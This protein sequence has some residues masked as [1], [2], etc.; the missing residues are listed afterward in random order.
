MAENFQL[1]FQCFQFVKTKDGNSRNVLVASA[2]PK[3]YSYAAESGQRLAVWPEDTPPAKAGSNLETEGP[4]EKRRKVDP[5][6]GE[7]TGGAPKKQ[8]ACWSNIPI[9]TS[10]PDGEYVVA[11]TAEDKCI[12][13]F[14]ITGNG[15]FQQLSARVMPKRAC[16]ITFTNK[17][18]ILCGDKFGD[19]Y[20]LP[21]I[22]S[23]EPRISKASSQ[24]RQ[25]A[26]ATPLTV[27]T[28]RN[29]KSLEMQ[30]RQ[31]SN[32]QV[33]DE[34]TF[35]HELLL[36]HVS[37]L[38]DVAFVSLP[39]RDPSSSR[40]RTYI[41]SA[42][43]DEHIRV[44]RGPPQAHVIENYCLGHTSFISKLCVPEWA[45]E[46][47]ISGGGD[48]F[49]FVW[50]WTQGQI[51]HKIPLV[52]QTPD[53]KDIAVSG[54]WAL[55]SSIQARVILVALEGRAELLCFTLEANGSLTAQEPIKV[56]GNVLNL[57][58]VE[59]SGAVLVSVDTIHEP[60]ST[61]EWR[62]HS[63]SPSALLEAFRPKPGAEKVEW[64]SVTDT[65]VRTINSTGTSTISVDAG[66]KEKKEL[67]NS[68]YSWE[69]LRKKQY[70][71]ADD[72]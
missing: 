23:A 33:V 29:L 6:S 40:K 60:G 21:L 15:S 17:N 44:S 18:D 62:S 48:P 57:Q 26:G 30:I 24:V 43:R 52:E 9:L 39:S 25:G 65:M 66:E 54:I 20:S 55:P 68:L 16:A 27:H 19:V 41:L 8:A 63:P 12:R 72:E 28:Q 64:E 13:V 49:L 2:G 3:I 67:N 50:N 37:L 7:T 61:Q 71:D 69:N 10:T 35:A 53:A 1:P 4:P 36:G 51:L 31:R 11:L 5:S 22:P 59:G 47:L 70:G 45:P 32:K 34:P 46:Y 42:D 56:S 38:T 14:Q 58:T